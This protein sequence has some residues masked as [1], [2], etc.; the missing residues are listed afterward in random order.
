VN[1][2]RAFL[3]D[4][5]GTISPRDIGAAFVKRFSPGKDV[6]RHALLERWKRGGMGHR[7]LTLAE[8]ALVSAEPADALAFTRTFQ[9]DPHF[10]AFVTEARARGDAV[11][12]VSEGFEFYLAD[13]LERNGLGD[14]P[15]ASN[16]VRFEAGRLIPEFPYAAEGCGACGNCKAQHVRHWHDDG[17]RTVLVGDGLSDRCGARAADIVFARGQL[18]AWCTVER[19]AAQPFYSFADVAAWARDAGEPS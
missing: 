11:M 10:P 4:F 14:L 8:C 1:A 15:R 2:R 12:V 9:L 18:L 5:D 7:E 17:F 16:R 6:E 3:C 13:Q 19:L